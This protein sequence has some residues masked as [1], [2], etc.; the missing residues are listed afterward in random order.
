MKQGSQEPRW[1]VEFNDPKTE[2]GTEDHSMYGAVVSS[3][4]ELVDDHER[5]IQSPKNQVAWRV[6]YDALR[7]RK[8]AEGNQRP[9]YMWTPEEQAIVTPS[10]N[11]LPGPADVPMEQ[12]V[13]TAKKRLIADGLYTEAGLVELEICPAFYISWTDNVK[14]PFWYIAFVRYY[15]ESERPYDE[16]MLV[17]VDDKTGEL[18]W[19][20]GMDD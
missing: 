7:E 6:E 17:F 10:H 15:P 14:V 12:A 11:G 19:Y 3:T 8:N 18:V 4:G 16:E 5:F 20:R 9:M 2:P 13:D 1:Y